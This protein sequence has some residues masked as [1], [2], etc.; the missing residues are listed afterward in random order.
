M[1]KIEP[2]CIVCFLR[3]A[4]KACR[5]VNASRDTTFNVIRNVMRVLMEHS[6]NVTPPDIAKHVYRVIRSSLGVHDPYARIKRLS[7]ELMLKIY[8]EVKDYVMRSE[9]PLR[10]AVMASIVANLID[11]AVI[12]D[13]RTISLRFKELLNNYLRKGAA[14]DDYD[15]LRE[16][17]LRSDK[18][19]F[20][21]DNAGEI[22]MDKLLLEVMEYVRGNPFNKVTFVVKGGPIINDATVEDAKYI[23]I[24]EIPNVNL[25]IVSN[26]DPG[27]GP[28][29]R[30]EEVKRWFYSH[31]LVI[32]K[33]QGN[34]EAFSNVKNTFF[35]LIS[36][37]N[38]VSKAL[39][40]DIGDAVIK[41]VK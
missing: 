30:D 8:R 32:L 33:G 29:I 15:K 39:N 7:N 12:D 16:Y 21:A 17:V 14:I 34:Y 3:Q 13:V 25:R 1:V 24:T 38:V 27:T 9:D 23:G 36:K 2:E 26:G 4:L 28:D 20:F 19:L 37:C 10:T 22:V 6:W 35:L 40:V 18:L 31:E 11:F 5:I 41:Y